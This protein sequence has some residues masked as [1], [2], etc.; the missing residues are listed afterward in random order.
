MSEVQTPR[1]RVRPSFNSVYKLCRNYQQVHF[2][3][4]VGKG[5]PQMFEVRSRLL[6]LEDSIAPYKK[7]FWPLA[8]SNNI[9]RIKALLVDLPGRSWMT[10]HLWKRP[11]TLDPLFLLFDANSDKPSWPCQLRPCKLERP[12]VPSG[13]FLEET[14]FSL[15]VLKKVGNSKR[16]KL[17]RF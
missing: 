15:A 1:K 6:A 14:T 13:N 10:H 4:H 7:F 3:G 2:K 16:S 9:S 12:Q 5:F 17:H 8:M 11:F